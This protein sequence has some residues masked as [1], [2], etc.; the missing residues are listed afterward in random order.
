MPLATVRPAGMAGHF[1]LFTLI[2]A[3]VAAASTFL[4]VA[5]ALP[6][7]AMF[8]GWVAY[9]T[10]GGGM[11]QGAGNLLSFLLGIGL[12]IGA[13]VAV[14]LLAPLLGDYAV[15]VVVFGL[16][17]LVL[18]L[19][20][21]PLISNPLAYFLGIIS[22]F[23]SMM[24]PSP[25]AFQTLVAAGVLGALGAGIAGWLQGRLPAK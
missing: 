14:G 8:L 11:R 22:F 23:A 18:S 2:G 15:S 21:L 1:H 9:S 12:G 5:L 7:W 6:A 13:S 25:A 16:V 4:T 3:V 19:R 10:G 20:A 17:M 24:G